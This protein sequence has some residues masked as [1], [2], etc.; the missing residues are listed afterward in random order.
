M[1][2]A[3]IFVFVLLASGQTFVNNVEKKL[4]CESGDRNVDRNGDRNGDRRRACDLREYRLAPTGRI[5]AG[6]H[7][8]GMDVKGW[9]SN[10]ILVRARVEV[11]TPKDGLAPETYL[12]QIQIRTSG[13][14][15]SSLEPAA[16]PENTWF[17][18]SYE[19]FVPHQTNLNLKSHNG[20][21][22]VRDVKGE[23]QFDMHNG[24][25]SLARVAGNVEGS[26]HNGGITLDLDGARWDGNQ[27]LLETHN[28][29][30]NLRVPENYS[31]RLEL[32]THNG[33]MTSDF[34]VTMTG[35]L[36]RKKE[37][38]FNLG[39]GGALIRMKTHNGGVALRRKS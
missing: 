13:G 36:A 29:G 24:G 28:G 25:V 3:P 32:S 9:A 5:T 39:S 38:A 4:S 26:S 2:L 33:G 14:Q 35:S 6:A 20:G 15:I 34:P 8:G 17:T 22:S 11:W 7:N 30:V 27:I 31:A 16:K 37:I 1:K 19:I 21:I 10:E 23:I 12:P 18:V